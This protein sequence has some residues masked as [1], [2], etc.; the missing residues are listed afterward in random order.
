M[1]IYYSQ[2]PYLAEII[3]Q[4]LSQSGTGNPQI[5]LRIRVLESTDVNPITVEQYERTIYWTLTEK[6]I[7]FT[8]DKL[9][10]LGFKG[11][12]FRQIDPLHQGH[13]SFIGQQID[14][15]CK[16]ETYQGK[17]REKWDLSFGGGGAPEPLDDSETRKLD[18]LFGR[19]L[20]EKCGSGGSAA[21][22]REAVAAMQTD[23]V[24]PNDDIP[25]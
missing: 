17:E 13:H 14:A 24:P 7:E 4:G 1:G 20:K 19:K 12:S 9:A 22:P 5:F 23:D 3:D 21:P 25:F 10:Q 6:T 8:L 16:V 18:A 11:T 2:G 15:Y